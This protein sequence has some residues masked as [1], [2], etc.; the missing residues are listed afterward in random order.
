MHSAV[1]MPGSMLIFGGSTHNGTSGGHCFSADFLLYDIK[2]NK[3]HTL[4]E[5]PELGVYTSRYGHSAIKF[6]TDMV[7]VAG[8]NGRMLGTILRYH[9]GK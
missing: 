6:R 3:W 9:P 5:P 7:I 1:L 2:C 8:F 4:P